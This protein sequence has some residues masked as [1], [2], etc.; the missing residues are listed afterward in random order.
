MWELKKKVKQTCEMLK[1]PGWLSEWQGVDGADL[2]QYKLAALSICKL[3]TDKLFGFFLFF[4][5]DWSSLETVCLF[6]LVFI[7]MCYLY[8][9]VWKHVILDFITLLSVEFFEKIVKVCKFKTLIIH[10]FLTNK[11]LIMKK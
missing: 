7:K 4:D 11:K 9:F 2:L 3:L 5:G 1:S 8:S 6:V 10:K